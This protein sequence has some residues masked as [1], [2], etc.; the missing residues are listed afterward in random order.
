VDG[1]SKPAF[2]DPSSFEAIAGLDLLFI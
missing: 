2:I 1:S